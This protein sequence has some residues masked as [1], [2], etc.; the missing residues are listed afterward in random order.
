MCRSMQPEALN[1]PSI[2]IY[3]RE[4]HQWQLLMAAASFVSLMQ[5]PMI[6]SIMLVFNLALLKRDLLGPNHHYLAMFQMEFMRCIIHVSSA[7]SV[8]H[9]CLHC[10]Q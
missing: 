7:L 3:E 2:L 1:D 5:L 8:H 10:N 9:K 4:L 6:S